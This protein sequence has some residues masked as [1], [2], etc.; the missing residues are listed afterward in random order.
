MVPPLVPP[1]AQPSN[2]SPFTCE[3]TGHQAKKSQSFRVEAV[4]LVGRSVE[5]KQ[6]LPG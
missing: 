3:D 5:A 6:G 2:S 4:P 1:T